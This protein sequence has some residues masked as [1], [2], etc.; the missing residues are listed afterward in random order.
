LK[1]HA[2]LKVLDQDP[3][4]IL[5]VITACQL[6]DC[7]RYRSGSRALETHIYKYGSY[8]FDLIAP[9]SVI[10]MPQVLS[11]VAMCSDPH[12]SHSTATQ[13]GQKGKYKDP[14]P[15]LQQRVVWVRVHPSAFDDTVSTLQKAISLALQQMNQG[16][17]TTTEEKEVLIGDLRGQINAFEIMGPKSNQVLKGALS[18]VHQKDEDQQFHKVNWHAVNVSS[19]PTY[20][21]F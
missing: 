16:G 21:L 17:E 20:P 19:I 5:L 18:P 11:D 12:Q 15:S 14:A 13:A 1:P 7:F 10:W 8:P 9:V 4:G 3:K 2:T 6:T